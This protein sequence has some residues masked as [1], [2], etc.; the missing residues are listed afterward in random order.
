MKP[1]E[2][3]LIDHITNRFS[4]NDLAAKYGV[5]RQRV[6]QWY[7]SYSL[8]PFNSTHKTAEKHPITSGMIKLFHDQGLTPDQIKAKFNHRIAKMTIIR[9]LHDMGLEPNRIRA[10]DRKS[11]FL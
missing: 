10:K 2:Q 1:S 11:W 5:S 3:E 7:N 8:K 9:R 6:H 4:A